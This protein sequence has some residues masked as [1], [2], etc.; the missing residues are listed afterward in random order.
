MIRLKSFFVYSPG[1]E[2]EGSSTFPDKEN[3]NKEKESPAAEGNEKK[4]FTEKIHDA[5]QEWSN[6]DKQEQEFDDT[7]P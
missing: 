6:Y 7:R 1:G 2:N 3:T 5:L 4:S